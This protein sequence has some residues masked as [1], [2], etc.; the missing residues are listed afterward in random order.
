MKAIVWTKYGSP[1]GLQLQEVEKPTPK[2][3]EVLIK[4]H[5][6]SVT[7]A[8]VEL[9]SFNKFTAFW[10]PM[11]M[12]I[13]LFKPTR[14]KILGQEVAGEIESIGKDVTKFKIGDSVYAWSALKLSGYAEYICLSQNAMMALKPDN[15]SYTEAAV[16]S[17]GAFEAW[18]YL[19][20]NVH[21]RQKVLIVGAG[22]TIG[23]FGVQI[24]K[25]FGAEVTA[26]DS[27][28][29]FD[30]LRSIGADHAIDYTQGDFIKINQT[31]D[32]I[33]DAPGK[34]SYARCKRLLKPDGKFLSAN[35]GTADQLRAIR[36]VFLRRRQSPPDSIIRRYDEFMALRELFATGKIKSI[37]D[38][39]YPL[40]QAAK[41]HR[42][43]ESG[44]KQGNIVIT[45]GQE[46]K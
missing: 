31:Y 45:M 41:A 32:V 36:N 33:F 22:G 15:I 24:A 30:M 6:A 37:I 9:R 44:M 28:G 25:Y 5:A 4:V 17:V 18:N 1:D 11:R 16:I 26:V 35:P 27:A 12:Y 3:N 20:G 21:A 34:T 10:L 8:D 42:Y 19:K 39:T 40:E 46:D 13:G 14:I 29:K 43:A 38:R 23:T 7:A 2:D